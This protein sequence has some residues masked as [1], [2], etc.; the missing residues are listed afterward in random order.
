MLVTSYNVPFSII[1]AIHIYYDSP[2]LKKWR[3]LLQQEMC[4]SNC[5]TAIPFRKYVTCIQ[6]KQVC[7][8]FIFAFLFWSTKGIIST[9]TTVELMI[10]N[11]MGICYSQ[12]PNVQQ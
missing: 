8:D 5:L 11:G 7:G 6:I 3:N 2:I 1:F 4:S 10:E 12:Y 9:G